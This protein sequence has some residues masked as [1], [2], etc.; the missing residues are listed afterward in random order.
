MY[1]D[2]CPGVLINESMPNIHM[3]LDADDVALVTDTIGRLQ[4]QLNVM[5]EFCSKY[6]LSVD[7]S[8][9][10]IMIFRNGY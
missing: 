7:M 3:L 4:H 5:S 8:K 1:N 9:T 2:T 6:Y 10:N